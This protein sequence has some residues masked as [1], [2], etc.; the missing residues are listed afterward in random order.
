MLK[1]ILKF[2]TTNISAKIL[3]LFFSLIIWIY[4]AS[5]ESKVG[6][7]PGQIPIEV[8]NVPIGK[9]VAEDLGACQIK[10]KAPYS[11][12]QNLSSD[13]FSA[14]VDLEG[15]DIGTH[16]LDVNVKTNNPAISII[17]KNPSKVIVKIEPLT[18]KKIPVSIKIEGKPSPGYA[19][20]EIINEPSE[21]EAYGAK[22][23]ID[24]LFNAQGIIKLNNEDSDIE[25]EVTLIAYNNS[26]QAIK[27]VNLQPSKIK[28]KVLI[29][30]ATNIKTVGIKANVVGDPKE[31]FWVSKII[32]YPSVATITGEPEELKN[33]EYLET[34]KINISD[35]DKSLD[36]DV[37]L[38]LP[39]G[40]ALV[41]GQNKI[42]VS[43]II[44]AEIS[45]KE[46]PATLIYKGKMGSTRNTVK[47]K[48]SG[49]IFLLN[50]LTS[51]N[52]LVIIDLT[53]RGSGSYTIEKKDIQIPQGFSL[54]DYSPKIINIS[55]D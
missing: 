47:V 2:F 49:P 34:E 41:A 25:R 7:F 45:V 18:S 6:N 38:I 31:N 21:V 13:S 36:K 39:E 46:L 27:N 35:L 37:E 20:G 11:V 4:V 9:A 32:V 24:S 14:Y 42:K 40:I 54:I 50:N 3:A 26:G 19:S 44:S 51:D 5:G 52:I 8:R 33:I 10:I 23:V 30:K 17:E 28:S 48:L 12:W 29:N 55:I 16:Q 22:S 15:V 43:V 1:K 53:G